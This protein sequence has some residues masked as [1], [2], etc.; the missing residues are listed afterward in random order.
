MLMILIV[1]SA[2]G[3]KDTDT[4]ETDVFSHIEIPAEAVRLKQKE[5]D[6]ITDWVLDDVVRLG[7][8]QSTY[9]T[10]KDVDLYA[11]FYYGDGTA[12]DM[13]LEEL[14][15]FLAKYGWW[16][17]FSVSSITRLQMDA[18][19]R[20]YAGI[21]LEDSEK[22]RLGELYYLEHAERWYSLHGDVA[23]PEFVPQFGYTDNGTIYL[24]YKNSMFVN[25]RMDGVFCVSM[26]KTDHGYQ[27]LANRFCEDDGKTVSYR[28]EIHDGAKDQGVPGE[29]DIEI[30]QL[31]PDAGFSAASSEEAVNALVSQAGFTE[32]TASGQQRVNNSGNGTIIIGTLEEEMVIYFVANN[33]DVFVLP[34][35]QAA[36][37][38]EDFLFGCGDR[39]LEYMTETRSPLPAN[40][41]TDWYGT[42]LPETN[43]LYIRKLTMELPA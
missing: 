23:H 27:Y 21:S 7:F 13:P 29:E 38:P 19:L 8:L 10:V 42:L 26:Q 5:L 33:G 3:V 6:E 20:E 1:M 15:Q 31:R 30:V 16:A 36:A 41:V 9:E 32:Q 25:T 39:F 17:D 28:V 14:R 43:E 11:L 34:V 22:I 4:P 40:A 24:Y 12:Y 37:K 18:Q 2:C 35:F